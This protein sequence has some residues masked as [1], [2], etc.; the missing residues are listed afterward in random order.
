MY[1]VHARSIVITQN[2]PAELDEDEMLMRA[3]AMSLEVEEEE[4]EENEEEREV[5][6]ETL[7]FSSHHGPGKFVKTIQYSE[8]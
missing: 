5:E 4:E 6:E 2:V 7:C 8:T 1:N 3:I